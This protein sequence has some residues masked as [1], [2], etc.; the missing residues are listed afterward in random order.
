[1]MK[2]IIYHWHSFKQAWATISK[3]PLEHLI[4]ILVLSLIITLCIFTLAINN[5]LNIW[6]Q[7]NI[8]YPQIM[9]YMDKDASKDDINSIDKSLKKYSKVLIRDFHFIS[10]EQGLAE[11]QQDQKLKEIASDTIE[12]NVNPLPDIF[13]IDTNTAESTE[14]QHL[15]LKL[16]QLPKVVD[17]QMDLA[18]AAKI[19]DLIGFS[20]Q[21]GLFCQCL[22][23]IVL[24][25]VVY[26][27]VRLQMLLKSDA[28][29]VSRLIG[30]SDSFIMRPLIHYAV[31]QVTLATIISA[32]AYCYIN[33]F[34]NG[35][36]AKFT[37]LFGSGFNLSAIPLLEFIIL[38][39]ILII[40][41][42]FTVFLA[43]RW[44]FR[45]THSN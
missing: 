10:K 28:I 16:G 11:L 40:F 31:W 27:M 32:L 4:N 5:S 26:N 24:S 30:A 7:K 37:N 1:M 9:L 38:W 42:I 25:L 20:N 14:L 8:V 35:L 23:I 2:K 6:Q 21:I 29:L 15:N 33:K 36:F 34:F 18:Y 22:F 41:T 44:V 43:V 19:R 13:V 12:S 45:N 17:V 39:I 3:S